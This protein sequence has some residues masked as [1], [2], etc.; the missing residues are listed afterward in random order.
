ML[1]HGTTARGNGSSLSFL[2]F[3]HKIQGGKSVVN[4]MMLLAFVAVVPRL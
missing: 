1:P 3:L 2:V 4:V